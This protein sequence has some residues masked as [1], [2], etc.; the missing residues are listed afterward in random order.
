MAIHPLIE[1]MEKWIK[2]SLKN[3]KVVA[4]RV[5]FISH[6]FLNPN[7]RNMGFVLMIAAM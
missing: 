3:K 2:N 6:F 5:L 4:I 1:T 7:D